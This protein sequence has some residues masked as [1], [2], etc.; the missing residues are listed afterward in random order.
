[1][2]SIKQTLHIG[3]DGEPT[4][5]GGT[6]GT[7]AKG[8]AAASAA[9]SDEV[10]PVGKDD[11]EAP[12]SV[13]AGGAVMS[14]AG[15]EEGKKGPAGDGM[16]QGVATPKGDGDGEE[17]DDD[18]FAWPDTWPERILFIMCFPYLVAFTYTIPDCSKPRWEKWYVV[19]Y[20][21]PPCGPPPFRPL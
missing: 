17:E 19:G 10:M 13:V 21:L 15:G 9:T 11:L 5:E 1:M 20:V 18:R 16:E 12:D 3:D 7:P 14:T 8:A 2:A 4:D 6:G